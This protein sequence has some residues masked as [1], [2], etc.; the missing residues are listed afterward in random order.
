ME[1]IETIH[2]YSRKQA[3]EDGALFDVTDV[4]RKAGIRHPVAMTSAVWARCMTPICT[5]DPPGELELL[6][7]KAVIG[8]GDDGTPVITITLPG[9][10]GTTGGVR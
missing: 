7:L 8:P 1:E 9:E 6:T 3:I 10:I 4:A 2:V 5:Y